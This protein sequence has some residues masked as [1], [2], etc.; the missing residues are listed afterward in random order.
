M[1]HRICFELLSILIFVSVQQ[2]HGQS[3]DSTMQNIPLD[4]ITF[5]ATFDSKTESK[6][7]YYINGYIVSIEPKQAKMLQG[8]KIRITGIVTIVEGL[9]NQPVKHDASGKV[10]MQQGRAKDTYLILSPHIEVVE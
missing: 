1:I 6:D 10:I 4:A 5:T 8:K 3:T 7:G 2:A 9:D